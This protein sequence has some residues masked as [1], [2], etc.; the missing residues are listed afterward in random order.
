MTRATFIFKNAFRNVRRA[1]LSVTSVA[2]SC[3]LLV[4]LQT[5]ERELTVPP[6]SEA[7]SP[8]RCQ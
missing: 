2:A 6:E 4:T 3:A 8:A 5:L 7:A 1:L